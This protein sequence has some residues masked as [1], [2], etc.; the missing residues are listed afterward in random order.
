ME[1]FEQTH[2]VFSPL[3]KGVCTPIKFY[4][5]GAYG[6]DGFT[7]LVSETAVILRLRTLTQDIGTMN[8]SNWGKT[9]LG[10][11][12]RFSQAWR[13]GKGERI[14]DSVSFYILSLSCGRG[15]RGRLGSSTGYFGMASGVLRKYSILQLHIIFSEVKKSMSMTRLQLRLKKIIWCSYSIDDY[16][17]F[18]KTNSI[19]IISKNQNQFS[20]IKQIFNARFKSLP[21]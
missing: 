2:W 5:G 8:Q 4:I 14:C 13:R 9:W 21:K 3:M 11:F 15:V 12:R 7:F 1:G 19:R 16:T 10:S 18:V 20:N 6:D 17:P